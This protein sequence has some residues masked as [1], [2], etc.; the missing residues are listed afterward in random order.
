MFDESKKLV[1]ITR[2]YEAYTQST[3]KLDGIQLY[4]ENFSNKD[5]S[6]KLQKYV[7]VF[8]L[9]DLFFE[10]SLPS[11]LLYNWKFSWNQEAK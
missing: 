1:S 11:L 8:C 3:L 6:A 4:P 2:T 10:S 5:P 7:D 9:I